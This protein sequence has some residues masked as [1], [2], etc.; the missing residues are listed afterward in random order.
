MRK[1][2]YVN[3]AGQLHHSH[4]L[5][6]PIQFCY[7]APKRHPS[8]LHELPVSIQNKAGLLDFGLVDLHI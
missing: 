7:K 3:V 6:A 1:L 8:T 5:D 2:A 4:C